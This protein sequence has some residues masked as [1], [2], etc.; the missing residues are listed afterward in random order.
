MH[1]LSMR[2]DKDALISC[3]PKRSRVCFD[4]RELTRQE[5]YSGGDGINP[6]CIRVTNTLAHIVCPYDLLR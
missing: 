3:V 1:Q 5:N 4:P 2:F 6:F